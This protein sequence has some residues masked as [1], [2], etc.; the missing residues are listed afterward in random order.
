MYLQVIN[1]WACSSST[2]A[3]RR[4][5]ELLL[6]METCGNNVFIPKPDRI[7]YNTMV[8]AMN[9][10]T[11]QE[12]ARAEELLNALERRSLLDGAFQPDVYTFTAVIS[13]YGRSDVLHKAEKTLELLERMIQSFEHGNKWAKPNTSAFNAALNACA[14]AQGDMAGKLNAF[15]IVVSVIALM[16]KHAKPD[17]TTYG[18]VLRACSSLLPPSDTRRELVVDRIFRQACQDGLVG[19]LVLTQLGFA[20]TPDHFRKL[21]GFESA[22]EVLMEELPKS[23]TANVREKKYIRIWP[24]RNKRT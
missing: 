12:A 10:G 13:A 17:H 3:V 4:A 15:D 8:K 20:A 14:F 1:A 19:K 21:T 23:W 24:G 11:K 18:T 5:E 16:K 7:T 9:R 6:E 22:G 2:V